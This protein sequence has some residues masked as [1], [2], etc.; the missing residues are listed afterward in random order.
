[1]HNIIVFGASITQG[2]FDG[3]GG[4]WVS[5]LA[6]HTFQQTID[7]KDFDDKSLV[8]NCGISGDTITRLEKRY[9]QELEPRMLWGEPCVAIISIG[10]N[11]SQVEVATGATKIPLDEYRASLTRIVQ[12][13]KKK[14]CAVFFV[15]LGAVDESKVNP[16]PWDLGFAFQNQSIR[17]F[18]V[19]MQEVAIAE[20]ATY[21]TVLDIFEDSME[22]IPDGIHPNAKGHRMMFERVKEHL[23]KGGIL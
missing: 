16:K 1:M 8:F 6:T 3:E 18:D 2:A 17:K 19:A 11:D 9:A 23:E 15:G 21:V 12:Y 7:S 22:L 5:R 10:I 14:Q 13:L 4:G 20:G